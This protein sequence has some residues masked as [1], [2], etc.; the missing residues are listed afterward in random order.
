M[1]K[2]VLQIIKEI[3]S[4][5]ELIFRIATF[6]VKATNQ[7]HYLGSLWQFLNPAIQ[8][9]I[10]WFVFGIGIRGGAAVDGTP[11]FLWLVIG[12]VPWFFIAPSIIQGSN[13]I[14]QKFDIVSKMNFPIS[15]LP[16][17]RIVS[18]SFQFFAMLF[19][20]LIVSLIYGLKPTLYTLQ[21][22]YYIFSMYIFL[23]S[24]T[25][26]TSTISILIRDFQLLLQSMM[27]MLFYLTPIL[28]STDLIVNRL[29]EKG[30]LLENILRLNPLYY[31]VEGFRD[32]VLAREWFFED[33]IYMLYFWSV[34]L[35][36]LFIGTKLHLRFKDNF[37]D[38]L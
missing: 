30:I 15:L 32:S 23:I 37:M 34:T 24:L 18:N 31:I 35:A 21:I 9:S 22:F 25:L 27:R 13:S 38:Y 11:F 12:L 14:H 33:P 17:I 2:S 16:T 3:I 28:W 6:E 7:N 29:G 8:I 4:H 1:F 26:I 20:M 10:Y 36:L 5:R 19:I